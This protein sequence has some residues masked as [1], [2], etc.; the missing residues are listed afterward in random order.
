[1]SDDMKKI[2][3]RC[4]IILPVILALLVVMAV[5]GSRPAKPPV[6]T[7]PTLPPSL[8]GP[9][10]FYFEGDTLACYE[11]EVAFGIDV[12]HHQGVIDWQA[13]ADSGVEFVF[14]RLGYRGIT[15]GE[16]HEDDYVRENLRGAKE[17]GLQ[18]GAYFYS[19]AITV[20]EARQEA[21]FA[22]EILGDTR[23]DLPLVFDWEQE[24]RT[25]NVPASTVT[26]SAIAFCEDI[27]LAGFTP[28][29]YFNGYQAEHQMDMARLDGYL[30]WLAMYDINE[31]FPCRMDYWQ[32]SCTGSVPGIEG[33]V[34]L[35]LMFPAEKE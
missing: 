25:E 22:L 20:E 13:V 34:D 12:S 32:Y 21:A 9:E 18:L 24:K 15:G 1:M 2:L 11:A 26:D 23:L 28:M 35:N 10:D 33:N 31:E 4:A 14:V 7:K 8:Y 30:W 17:A 19:Q 16:L 29:V 3:L 6:P 27:A 5:V